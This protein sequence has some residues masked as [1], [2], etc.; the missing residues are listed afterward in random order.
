MHALVT[1]QDPVRARRL[2]PRRRAAARRDQRHARR[3]GRHARASPCRPPSRSSSRRRC[4]RS[5]SATCCRRSWTRRPPTDVRPLTT[6]CVDQTEFVVNKLRDR[7]THQAF[8]VVTNAQDFMHVLRFYV[9][10]WEQS[11][12]PA[13]TAPRVPRP[14]PRGR[15]GRAARS[16][17]RLGEARR[18]RGARGAA[19]G[20]RD[21]VSLPADQARRPGVGHGGHHAPPS[22]GPAG[23]VYGALHARGARQGERPVAGARSS[24]VALSPA[25]VVAQV[26][27]QSAERSGEAEPP[28][29]VGR[30]VWYEG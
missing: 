29:A 21:R 18:R 20:D 23:G 9:E 7:G 2:D 11:R 28:L 30:G 15:R 6:I 19:R 27:Q 1:A 24:E 10:R 8:G 12:I 26:M 25:E 14:R 17:P 13:P 4:T 3:A 22:R 16:G 5:P